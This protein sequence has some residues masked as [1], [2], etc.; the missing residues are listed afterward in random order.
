MTKIPNQKYQAEISQKP[1]EQLEAVP[2]ALRDDYHHSVKRRLFSG[3]V[4]ALGGRLTTVVSMLVVNALLA[5]MLSPADLGQYF[6]LFSLVVVTALVAQLGLNRAGVRLIAEALARSEAEQ[7]TD[8]AAAVLQIGLV[9]AVLVGLL[10]FAGV[11]R[12]VVETIMGSPAI[13]DYLG[14][15]ATW[16]AS[17]AIVLLMA[18]IFR[19]YHE[20]RNATLFNGTVTNVL[21]AVLLGGLW[22]AKPSGMSLNAVLFAT[23]LATVVS[24][25]AAAWFLKQLVRVIRKV[26]RDVYVEVIREAWPLFL[27][28]MAMVV[29][30]QA[31]LWI[32]ARY[33]PHT[34]VAIYGAA[35]RLVLI[36]FMPL[37][38]VSAALSPIITEM[39]TQKR[40]VHLERV[41]RAVSTMTS[42]PMILMLAM[43]IFFGG[44]ILGLV[45]GEYYRSGETIL[46]VLSIS[47]LFLMWVGTAD[48]T[49]MLTGHRLSI[50]V[51]ALAGGT[52]SIS[53]AL[54]LVGPYGSIGVAAATATGLGTFYV[55]AWLVV[56]KKVGVWTH[57]GFL[58]ASHL[59]DVWKLVRR[60][61]LRDY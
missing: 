30:T 6:L 42:I 31:D 41:L 54:L 17:T 19:G 51:C 13:T 18:E 7:A 59:H 24:V 61:A 25:L 55:A 23:V 11:G 39:H 37:L 8:R 2:I 28:S 57:I 36:M 53:L 34:E 16:A 14:Y 33:R 43:F 50:L 4:W 22:M 5:R 60:R 27:A 10:L 1:T 9:S 47:Y 12:W 35:A 15:A 52:I 29:L 20:V 21:M 46:A 32:L 48:T 38:I 49:L 56:R 45:Y 3:T 44:P 26:S 40:I 58:N